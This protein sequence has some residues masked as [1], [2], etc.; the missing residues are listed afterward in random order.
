MYYHEVIVNFRKTSPDPLYELHLLVNILQDGTDL[1]IYPQHFTGNYIIAYG[2]TESL[3]DVD[4][5]KIYDYHTFF[6]PIVSTAMTMN[7]PLDVNGKRIINS[8][9]FR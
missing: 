4:V 9:S 2:T 6:K 8:L 3:N 5:D 1:Q 7:A